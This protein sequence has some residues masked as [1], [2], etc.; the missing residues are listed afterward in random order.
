RKLAETSKL[1]ADEIVQLAGKSVNVA[2]HTQVMLNELIPDITRTTNLVEEITSA[3][4]EQH[5]GVEQVNNAIQQQNVVA[6]Q[7]AAIS[8]EVVTTSNK[9]SEFANQ[10]VELVSYFKIRKK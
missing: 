7:N 3:S 2:Q 5:V 8:E 9:L 4:I 6:Q 10:F 1:A